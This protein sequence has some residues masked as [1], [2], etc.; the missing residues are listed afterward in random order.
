MIKEMGTKQDDGLLP[1]Y[2]LKYFV[3]RAGKITELN[4]PPTVM[5]S[6][7]SVDVAK[8]FTDQ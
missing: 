7:D 3:I 4:N 1:E 6:V 2:E 8:D 5:F